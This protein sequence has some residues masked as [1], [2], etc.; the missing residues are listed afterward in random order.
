MQQ[1]EDEENAAHH[2][3]VT[4]SDVEHLRR[5]AA[6]LRD[7]QAEDGAAP[8][9]HGGAD[10][11]RGGYAHEGGGAQALLNARKL[12]RTEVLPGKRSHRKAEGGRRDFQ[13]AVQLVRG[14]KTGDEQEAEAVDDV[15]HAHAAHGDDGVLKGHRRAQANQ[16]ADGGAVGHEVPARQAQHRQVEGRA[17]AEQRGEYL[18]DDRRGRGARDAPMKDDDEQKV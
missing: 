18:R 8:D 1:V 2:A 15:L 16:R 5:A 4:I 12:L 17:Q 10:T 7:E 3:Q 13:Q 6:R 9:E 11:K 14:G